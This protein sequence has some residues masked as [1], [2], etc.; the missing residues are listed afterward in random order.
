MCFECFLMC[1]KTKS[2]PRLHEVPVCYKYVFRPGQTPLFKT[3]FPCKRNAY[4]YMSLFATCS[5]CVETFF[6]DFHPVQ[7]KRQFVG[8]ESLAEKTLPKLPPLFNPKVRFERLPKLRFFSKKC[9]P[10]FG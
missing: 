6:G 2:A 1:N 4:L 3:C 5:N 10:K 9:V 7:A 8:P